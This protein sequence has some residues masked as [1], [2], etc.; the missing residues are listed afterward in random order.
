MKVK[1]RLGKRKAND[2]SIAQSLKEYNEEVHG[3]GK[4][5]PER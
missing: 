1:K 3:Q 5:L 2:Q 4:T